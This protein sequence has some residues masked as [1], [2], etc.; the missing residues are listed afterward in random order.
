[1]QLRDG[2]V[3]FDVSQYVN[4]I[5]LICINSVITG[6][7]SPRTHAEWKE[8][9]VYKHKVHDYPYVCIDLLYAFEGQSDP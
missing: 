7:V 4:R 2:V 5:K 1:M 6:S 8:C 9:M 3:R